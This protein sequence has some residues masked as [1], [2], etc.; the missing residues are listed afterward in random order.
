MQVTWV[1]A[2]LLYFKDYFEVQLHYTTVLSNSAIFKIFDFRDWSDSNSCSHNCFS[3]QIS[4]F[5][6][7]GVAQ[8]HTKMGR[9]NKKTKRKNLCMHVSCLVITIL[10]ALF[11]CDHDT[12]MIRPH[13]QA[14]LWP[15]SLI[16]QSFL[17]DASI[18]KDSF[19]LPVPVWMSRIFV[20]LDCPLPQLVYSSPAQS[21]GV[22]LYCCMEKCC[23]WYASNC[24]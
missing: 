1:C 24:T 14:T 8:E 3:P 9:K 17:A 13:L 2:L 19:T 11:F 4:C 22:R 6:W 15:F 18:T 16:C 20:F 12:W 10:L 21:K 23:F 7:N 5:G